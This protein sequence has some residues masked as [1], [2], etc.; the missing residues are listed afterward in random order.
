MENVYLF[1]GEE[2]Y[3]E[4]PRIERKKE[5]IDYINEFIIKKSKICGSGSL[6]WYLENSSYEEWLLFKNNLRKMPCKGYVKGETFYL[7]RKNDNKIIGMIDLRYELNDYLRQFGGHVGYS[8][9][10]SERKKGYNKINLYL[11]LKKY[12]EKAIKEIMISCNDSNLGSRKT[13]ESFAGQFVRNEIDKEENSLINI[14]YVNVLNSLKIFENNSFIGKDEII[15]W[16][17]W[18]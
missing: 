16:N 12:K 10:P 8:I 7:I 1:N 15:K 18:Y 17:K 2:F 4:Y 13:I 9:R 3:L 11:A 14:Y 5:A 6:D